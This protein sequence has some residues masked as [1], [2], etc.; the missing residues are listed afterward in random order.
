MR[1]SLIV[2][3]SPA[4]VIGREG[5]LPWR[6]SSDLQRFKRL[7]MGHHLIMGRTTYESIGR[8]LPGRTSLVLSRNEDFSIADPA[9]K[10]VGN[11]EQAQQVA[12]SAGDTEAFVIGGGQIYQLALPHA[13]RMYVTHVEAEVDGD[14]WF[15]EWNVTD[16]ELISEESINADAKNEYSSMYRVYQRR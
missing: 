8:P 5:D 14:A 1:L 6:L 2:A 16:W 12:E 9:V 10:V 7:T 4:R 11:L 13:E 15:P 3:M